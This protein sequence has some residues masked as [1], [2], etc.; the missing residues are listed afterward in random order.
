[1][2]PDPILLKAMLIAAK[3][4]IIFQAALLFYFFGKDGK[5][6]AS[7]V[8]DVTKK[9]LKK[10]TG[11]VVIKSTVIP[12]VVK[13]LSDSYRV[14]YNPEFLREGEKTKQCISTIK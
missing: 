10:T 7:I 3:I 5:I 1:M 13:Y 14:I 12:S 8:I 4:T 11:L 9:L 6:D 2:I